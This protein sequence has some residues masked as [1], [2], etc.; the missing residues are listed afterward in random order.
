MCAYCVHMC[1]LGEVSLCCQLRLVLLPQESGAASILSTAWPGASAE[2]TYQVLGHAVLLGPV[3]L[4]PLLSSISLN[5]MGWC[6][7]FGIVAGWGRG[8]LLL[9]YSFHC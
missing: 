9:S 2:S 3:P 8:S 4:P 6:S 5:N 7:A 1:V